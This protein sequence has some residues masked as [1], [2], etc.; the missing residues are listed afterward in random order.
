VIIVVVGLASL[1]PKSR[2][3]SKNVLPVA[4]FE[5]VD[6]RNLTVELN[7]SASSDPDGTIANYSWNFG[8]DANGTGVLVT[9]EYP[10]NGTY[11][12]T[13][14]VTD[15][16]G[17]QNHTSKHIKVEKTEVEEKEDPVAAIKVVSIVNWTVSLSASDSYDPDGGDISVYLW[18]FGD[19]MTATGISV[20][21]TYAANG[22][23]TV[24]LTVTD[25]DG[26]NDTASKDVT[27]VKPMPPSPEPQGPPGLLHAIEIHLEKADR[28]KGLQNSLEHL[29][30]NLQK[31]IQNHPSSPNP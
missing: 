9:H 1:T 6:V 23:Y 25:D 5:V 13:L 30:D 27:V 28:N 24:T 12:V 8:D 7:A 16:K 19:G 18:N 10:A 11:N 14:T 26:A 21:H 3:E 20:T 15:D 17:G 4:S 22:T 31:W 2:P 29:Q